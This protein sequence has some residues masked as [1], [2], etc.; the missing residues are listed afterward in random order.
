LK[1]S[2]HSKRTLSVLIV[3]ALAL[4]VSPAIADNI[5]GTGWKGTGGNSNWSTAGNW[6]GDAPTTNT[7]ND[8]NLFFGQGYKAAGGAGSTTSNNDLASWAGYRITFQDSNAA[9]NGTDGSSAN[10]TAFT[11]TGNSFTLFDFGTNNFP[12]VENDSFLTQTFTLTSGSTITLSGGSNNKAEIDP[13]NGNLLFSTGTKIDLAGSTQL[14]MFGGKTV[15]Y[16]GIISS[17]GNSGNNSVVINGGT[18]AVYGAVN[19]YN[20]DTFVN[21][22]ILQIASGGGVAS[23]SAIRLGNSATGSGNASLVFSSLTGGLSV[24]SIINPGFSG[25]T[26]TYLI[27]SQ[28][29]SNTN[30]ISGNIFL[31]A[32]LRIQQATGGTLSITN[33]TL[34]LKGNTL[35]FNTGGTA[36]TGLLGNINITGVIGNSAGSG[37]LVVGSD[38]VA[39]SGGTVTLS[40]ANTYTGQT[41]VRNGTLAFTSAGSS[42]SSTIRFGSA[43]G[44]SVDAN[45]N[46]TSLTGGTTISS[47]VNP[48]TTSGTGTL[49]INSQNTSNTNTFS[50]HFGEDRNLSINQAGGG[51]LAFTQARLNATDTATAF[52]IKTTTVTLG[53]AGNITFNDVYNSTGSG[54]GTLLSNSTGTVTLGGALDNVSL[55]ATVNSGT[56]VLAKTSTSAIHA[57]EGTL[58]I[59]GGTAQLGNTSGDQILNT[60][61]VTVTSGAFDLNAAAETFGTLSV[62][63]TGI[64]GAGA[65]L[66]SAASGATGRINSG[67]GVTLTGDATFGTTNSGATLNL[68]NV[69]IT[70]GAGT[71]AITKVGAGDLVLGNNG[72]PANGNTFDGGVNDNAG[73]L[74]VNSGSNGSPGAVTSGPLGTGTLT[75]NGGAI[76]AGGGFTS[77]SLMNAI[78]LAADTTIAGGGPANAFVL[79]GAMTISGATRT[80]TSNSTSDTNF[81][82]AIGG[83][84]GLGLTF[85][86]TTTGKFIVSGAS[87]YTGTTTINAGTLSVDSA[88]STS[89]RLAGTSGITV[90]SGGT[91]LLANSTATASNDRINNSAA[92]KLNGQGSTTVAFNT[93]GLQEHG[94]TNNTAGLGALTLQSNSIIDLG[95]GA[96]IIAFANSNSTLGN[97]ATW[98]GTLS[99]YN[100]TGN[101]NPV[102][103]GGTD[104]LFVGNDATGLNAAQ[105]AQVQFFSGN[106]T[107]SY[108]LGAMIL[109]NGEVVPVPEPGTWAAGALV[110]ASLLLTQRKRLTLLVRRHGSSATV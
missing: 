62:Q 38:G 22:G 4:A 86:A 70:D 54:T 8:R 30:T 79:S 82:G 104:Q 48:V 1:T 107:G 97:S 110:F 80:L 69:V 56:L 96:S 61:N 101:A 53:G 49:T 74:V 108:G 37:Q 68:N 78:N 94:A 44:T 21:N 11:I 16:N 92:I 32:S 75:L 72:T 12:R 6:D 25:G 77:G 41:F 98:V 60:A 63:G 26:G 17:S 59:A 28:N 81:S 85:N 45:I 43:T 33:A 93:A 52:D 36:N 73:T 100:W 46:L 64:S 66:T 58:T 14:Q 90:N 95:S 88:G 10:D 2:S 83:A 20:G 27:D 24:G 31:D 40:N 47:T 99:I 13:V 89:A 34:D 91:L 9:G 15:T 42:N 65:L 19:T 18:T 57:I 55:A 5:N 106:N 87:T 102:L 7:S 67:T 35:S 103:G 105:L 50:G 109:S 29:T 76:R 51:T 3:S 84:A 23:G 39:N 71:F